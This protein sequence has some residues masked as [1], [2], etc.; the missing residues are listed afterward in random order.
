MPRFF[1]QQGNLTVD[2][3]NAMDKLAADANVQ[4]ADT[5][6]DI[7][8]NKAIMTAQ[9]ACTQNYVNCSA[10]V[11]G[12]ECGTTPATLCQCCKETCDWTT[13]AADTAA[14][15]AAGTEVNKNGSQLWQQQVVTFSFGGNY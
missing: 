1:K 11:N 6:I 2:C 8:F 13:Y 10:V 12:T 5:A 15:E 3:Q 9:G 7:D 14:Y 4:A